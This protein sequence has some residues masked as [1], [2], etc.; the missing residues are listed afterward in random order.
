LPRKVHGQKTPAV[1]GLS[2]QAM[3]GFTVDSGDGCQ[4]NMVGLEL[5]EDDDYDFIHNDCRSD[6][7]VYEPDRGQLQAKF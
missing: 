1:D 3:V 6:V 7:N 4:C 2:A 5:V